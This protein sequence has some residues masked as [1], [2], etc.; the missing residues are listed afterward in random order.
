MN[1][2]VWDMGKVDQHVGVKSIIKPGDLRLLRALLRDRDNA[3]IG[4]SLQ[5]GA[6]GYQETKSVNELPAG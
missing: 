3:L 2:E 5:Q 1:P 4:P 6:I